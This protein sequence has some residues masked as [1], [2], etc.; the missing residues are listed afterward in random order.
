MQFDACTC[1]IVYVHTYQHVYAVQYGLNAAFSLFC[2][3]VLK[4][5]ML[6]YGP[7]VVFTIASNCVVA[8]YVQ[9][10]NVSVCS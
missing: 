8:I 3:R 9:F 5:V 4:R 1:L 10:E 2:T 6:A 7:L